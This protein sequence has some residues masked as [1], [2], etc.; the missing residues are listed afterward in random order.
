[1]VEAI[2]G[3]PFTPSDNAVVY[4]ADGS[5]LRPAAASAGYLERYDEA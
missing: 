2:E 1:M 4:R 5:E 3:E